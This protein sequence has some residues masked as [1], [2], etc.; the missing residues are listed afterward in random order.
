[1]VEAQQIN[2]RGEIAVEG[3]DANGNNHAVLL[4]P[5]DENHAGVEACDYSLVDASTASQ[6][7]PAPTIQHPAALTPHRRMLRG[8]LNHSRFS[9]GQ[10]PTGFGTPPAPD[11]KPAIPADVVT[12]YLE[13]DNV[14]GP[15]WRGGYCIVVSG[16][17]TGYCSKYSYYS[18]LA[19]PSSF[20]PSGQIAKDPGY[21]SCSNTRRTFVDL[22]RGCS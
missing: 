13:A 4:I 11:S 22:G 21:Y 1:L 12:D 9:R 20:C 18:C 15:Q 16:K 5:C 8:M 6:V 3:P 2:D 19:K 10:R 17:L 7:S 14:L